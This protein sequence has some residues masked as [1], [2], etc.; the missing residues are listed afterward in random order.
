LQTKGEGI[1]QLQGGGLLILPVED[2]DQE[3]EPSDLRNL[4]ISVK[5]TSFVNNTAAEGAGIYTNW[6][7]NVTNCTFA[8]NNATRAVRGGEEQLVL[9]AAG[10]CILSAVTQE[11]LIPVVA[12]NM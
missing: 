9:S 6:P 2:K 12:V 8:A 5:N 3:A 10:A 7:M 4:I 11:V 1:N